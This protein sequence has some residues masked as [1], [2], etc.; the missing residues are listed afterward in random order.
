MTNSQRNVWRSPAFL[1]RARTSSGSLF[2]NLY[3]AYTGES[4]DKPAKKS[5]VGRLSGQ[6]RYA[7]FVPSLQDGADSVLPG[8]PMSEV[9][10]IEAGLDSARERSAES[11]FSSAGDPNGVHSDELAHSAVK[12]HSVLSHASEAAVRGLWVEVDSVPSP[13]G[14]IMMETTDPREGTAIDLTTDL[15]SAE[16]SLSSS[17]PRIYEVQSGQKYE[18]P[19]SLVRDPE[20][21]AT[22][23][24]TTAM[25]TVDTETVLLQSEEDVLEAPVLPGSPLLHPTASPG[26]PPVSPITGRVTLDSSVQEEHQ[27]EE[28]AI[29][30]GA[31]EGSSKS[32]STPDVVSEASYQD[33]YPARQSTGAD[34]DMEHG[35]SYYVSPSRSEQRQVIEGRSVRLDW[36][37]TSH[38]KRRDESGVRI[39]PN[40]LVHETLDIPSVYA[41]SPQQDIRSELLSS[42]SSASES[43]VGDDDESDM[44]NFEGFASDEVS[45]AD[46]TDGTESVTESGTLRRASSEEEQSWEAES[47]VE[48]SNLLS[49]GQSYDAEDAS[50]KTIEPS[51]I[52]SP[53]VV[54]FEDDSE[55]EL[56]SAAT[57]PEV[58]T[59]EEVVSSPV[60]V[61][62]PSDD[63]SRH[64]NFDIRSLNAGSAN[65]DEAYEY[66]NYPALPT[67]DFEQPPKQYLPFAPAFQNAE[68]ELDPRRATQLFTPDTTQRTYEEQRVP[69]ELPYQ[70]HELP[71]PQ[72][73]QTAS[74]GLLS[75]EAAYPVE[76]G[77]P[78]LKELRSLTAP[79]TKDMGDRVTHVPDAISPWFALK[80]NSQVYEASEDDEESDSH[81]EQS[82]D[83]ERQNLSYPVVEGNGDSKLHLPTSGIE[84]ETTIGNGHTIIQSPHA[85]PPPV[86]LR[87]PLSYFSP[88]VTIHDHFASTIDALAIVTS[89]TRLQRSKSGPKDYYLTFNITDPSAESALT[90]VQIFRPFKEALPLTSKGVAILLRNFKVQSQKHRF[91][92]VST[93]SSAWAVFEKGHSVQVNGPPVEVGAEE[94]GFAKGLIQWWSSLRRDVQVANGDGQ[95]EDD[96]GGDNILTRRTE[97]RSNGVT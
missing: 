36:S 52:Q 4:L 96:D 86:G 56:Q 92:L 83:S 95:R 73:T 81:S 37:K 7:G 58:Q 77:A 88:L 68:A 2:D 97:Y 93:A 62:L 23:S 63:G 65:E 22:H 55:D 44:E 11:P 41:R 82:L 39:S 20:G 60:A 33:D 6:W 30:T 70:D 67:E 51:S 64:T 5:K 54:N 69:I 15:L 40:N 71:T 24:G 28:S 25:Q 38:Q 75:L 32:Q 59:L 91:T 47:D 43:E 1:K 84:T 18:K 16:S 74:A 57:S 17:T 8:Q 48:D 12:A 76:D 35:G 79:L 66:I 42:M 10:G 27:D 53:E 45:S 72:L 29:N 89:T 13:L 87:T 46:P 19:Y 78:R 80:R 61:S 9:V 3:D 21:S 26:L 34:H 50:N 85:V 14:D 31:E 49:R 90:S 94:R